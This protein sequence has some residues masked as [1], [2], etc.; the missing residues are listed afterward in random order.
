[1]QVCPSQK[2]PALTTAEPNLH[3]VGVHWMTEEVSLSFIAAEFNKQI[4]HRCGFDPLRHHTVAKG[5][6]QGNHC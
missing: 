1:M 5:V 4:Q 3:I 2:G 6:G